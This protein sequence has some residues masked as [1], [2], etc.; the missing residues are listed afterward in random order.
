VKEHSINI[1]LVIP[2]E[3]LKLVDKT[4]HPKENRSAFIRKLIE[5]G[6]KRVKD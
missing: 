5:E 6:L 2:R 3:L 4:K 1:T